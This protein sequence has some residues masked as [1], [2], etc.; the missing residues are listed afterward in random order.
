MSEHKCPVCGNFQD[1]FAL[2]EVNGFS[3]YGCK[4]CGA[5]HVFPSPGSESLKA[6][7]DRPE[8][9]EGG[10]PGG[11]KNYDQQTEWSV[12]A[13]KP[14]L[15]EFGEAQ[16]LS[17]LDIGCGY[18]TH[19]ELAASLGWKCFGVEVS[20][21]ARQVAQER[22]AGKA[23][24][25]ESVADLIPHEFD[26]VIMLD[27]IEHLP[28]PYTLF[29]SLFSIGAI[30]PKTRIVIST[31]NAG[32]D[33]ARQNPAAWIYRHPPS[34]L[35]YYSADALR[36]L[37]EKLHFSNIEV[38]GA[39][40]LQS[41]QLDTNDIA[42]YGGLLATAKGSDFTEFMRERFV[43]GTWS[44]LAEYEHLPRYELSKAMADGKSV[45]DFG[46]GTGYGSAILSE[47][48]EKVIGLDIDQ[49]A[50]FWANATHRNPRLSF[51]RCSD[52]G[53]SLPSGSFDAITCFEMIEHVDHA[54]QLA[55]IASIARLLR[56]DGVLI[57]S[58]PNPEIT[59]L[60]GANPYHLREM[61]ISEFQELLVVHFPHICILE[62]RVRNSIAFDVFG[63]KPA[64]QCITLA[65]EGTGVI[66]LAYIAFCSRRPLNEIRSHV[67]F[68]EE[69]DLI[70]ETLTQEK[71][72]NEARFD[73]YRYSELAYAREAEL[74]QQETEL[75]RQATELQLHKA[76]VVE[77]GLEKDR[78]NQVLEARAN[79]IIMLEQTILLIR[80]S[81]W[82]RLGEA[83]KSRSVAPINIARIAYLIAGLITPK[84]LRQKISPLVAKWRGRRLKGAVQSVL[85]QPTVD[86]NAYVVRKP[87]PAIKNPPRI[88]HVIANFCTGGS[89][90]LVVDLIEQLGQSYEQSVITGFIP[91][92]PDYMGL[93]IIE[94]RFPA[95]EQPF[96]GHLL[97]VKPMLIHIHYWGDCDQSWYTHAFKAAEILGIPVIE[98]I[99]TP[100]T[101]YF[102]SAVVRYVYVSNYVREVFGRNAP[103]HLTIYP[104][105]DFSHFFR[106]P[107]EPQA[108]NCVGMVY[109][110]EHDKLNEQSIQPFI[111]IVQRRP[112]TR[113]LIVGGGSLLVPF[114][115]AVEL[116]GVKE[117]FEFTGY[118][119]YEKLPELYRRMSVF[120]APIWKE[121]FGQVSAFAMNMHIPVI[122]YDIG[123]L[124]EIIPNPD[125]LAPPADAEKLA[126][127]AINLLETVELRNRIG[128][129][130]HEIAQN[131]FSLQ[132]MVQAY[133][134]VYTEIC[135]TQQS[136][137]S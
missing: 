116:A 20:A 71:K 97:R 102:S 82:H 23:Y 103:S 58:T 46:C 120:I 35:T 61:T 47:V 7:Y 21:H 57:I 8:W 51:H 31:P 112:Q 77:L 37:L 122:G 39:H 74:Q 15:D 67:M 86:E 22:L 12:D 109:R 14:V 76:T 85:E 91:N 18:G 83:L 63:V 124:G 9:F 43:P 32:S 88:V 73:S 107:N 66:P 100:T 65:H 93:D 110:L 87:L 94:I 6:Y 75:Q 64:T 4:A 84:V 38:Q 72:L 41:T 62:Q 123:A 79:E 17:V 40:L 134:N 106:A 2:C 16:G 36:I 34:H 133:A 56:E 113:V 54:T 1:I 108:E 136:A 30:T 126:S 70:R 44:K 52:L 53:A 104:G 25:V 95:D 114:Q 3:V 96:I 135:E 27:V 49:A 125:L 119:S 89:S 137:V 101:P 130:Q 29:Y 127:I 92:P 81:K 131:Q 90:R 45:L 105:S 78:L 117:C 50:I 24:I 11:Y 98:N 19:L 111:R 5:D 121:S 118:V 69:V 115:K 42:A 132:S 99:N 80:Q 10:E 33:E 55:V 59:K 13:I 129:Q 48:A 26:L 60:Y 28:S 68:D 128:Q